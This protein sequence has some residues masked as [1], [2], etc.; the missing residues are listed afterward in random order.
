M[1]ILI[2]ATQLVLSLSLLILLHEMGHFLPAKWFKTRVE[3]FY[4]FFDPY[5]SLF[6]FKR[7][8]TEY[9]I[10]NTL[11]KKNVRQ[12]Q[13]PELFMLKTF[14]LNSIFRVHNNKAF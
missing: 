11:I 10:A 1:D 3:K 7:G 2:K 4:L 12:T 14:S 5:F 13:Y 8:E 9:G 6:K